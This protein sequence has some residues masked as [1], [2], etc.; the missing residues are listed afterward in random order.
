VTSSL[1]RKGFEQSDGDHAFFTY[2]RAS[3]Q[4]KTAVFTKVSHGEVEVDDY[5]LGKM[6]QQC[7][8]TKADF[9][10]LVDCPLDRAAYEARL[11][12]RGVDV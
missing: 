1:K 10:A 12:S 2:Y 3:D 11:K 5:L 8:L 7:K 4:K 6:A 9:L